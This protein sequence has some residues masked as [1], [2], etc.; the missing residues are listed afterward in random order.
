FVTPPPKP[1]ELNWRGMAPVL[2]GSTRRSQLP[3]VVQPHP[4]RTSVISSV[5]V[6][7]LVNTK[8][9]L[10]TTPALVLPKSN[11]V[12]SNSILGPEVAGWA[13]V[14]AAGSD[15]ILVWARPEVV[16]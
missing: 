14:A 5:A 7:V 11:T 2:P 8:A 1:V 4:G 16:P 12:A 10:T 9:C 3:A 13:T 6:P 15:E